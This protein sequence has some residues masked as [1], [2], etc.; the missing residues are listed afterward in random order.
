MQ[1]NKRIFTEQLQHVTYISFIINLRLPRQPRKWY[2]DNGECFNLYYIRVL[3][4]DWVR[5]K[6]A[7]GVSE[8]QLSTCYIFWS[9]SVAL[10]P[11]FSLY[12]DCIQC[13]LYIYLLDQIF[14]T[15]YFSFFLWGWVTLWTPPLITLPQVYEAVSLATREMWLPS[16]K[17]DPS[18]FSSKFGS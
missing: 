17:L 4:D 7:I 12:S 8:L 14:Q 10:Y 16:M 5:S 9:R 3:L 6:L 2:G 11:W 18:T 15:I 1:C 13:T